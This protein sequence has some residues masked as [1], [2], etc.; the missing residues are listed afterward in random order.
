MPINSTVFITGSVG[1]AGLNS[2]PDVS[3][4]Q[5]RLND[6]MNRPREPLVVDGLSGP[7]TEGV[8]ADFQSVVLGFRNPDRR[9]DPMGKTIGALNDPSSEGKWAMMSM[10]PTGP[11]GGAG[12]V[13]DD[14]PKAYSGTQR[15]KIEKLREAIA[16][17]PDSQPAMDFIDF[18]IKLYVPFTKEL[19]ASTT[20]SQAIYGTQVSQQFVNFVKGIVALRRMGFTAREIAEVLIQVKNSKGIDAGTR[21]L[22]SLGKYP[23]L[24]AKLKSLGRAA[25]IAGVVVAVIEA[26]NHFRKGDI[27][28][29]MAEIY[30]LVMGIAVP[31]AALI[32][33]AQSLLFAY[34]PD[35]EGSYKVR[36]ALR[37]LNAINPIGAG[38]TAID[39]GY[40]MVKI[41]GQRIATGEWNM[42]EL[43][44]L[45][46]RMEN[47]PMRLFTEAGEF[48]GDVLGDLTGDWFYETFLK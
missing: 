31:W 26:G 48:W 19:L 16:K 42:R 22:G 28:P 12:G 33:A 36:Y 37:F 10:A 27:G 11:G 1:R 24:A 3:A 15:E 4:I 45:V 17:V 47:S 5:Q 9:V 38:K 18:F 23:Q 39:S 29:G 46:N 30:G 20:I 32:D 43:D 35:L 13:P 44:Y 2:K 6:L 40:T 7:K 8:I 34:F 21:F 41:V 25:V 14:L